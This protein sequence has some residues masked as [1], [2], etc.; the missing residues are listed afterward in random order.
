MQICTICQLPFY[1]HDR[2]FASGAHADIF[3]FTLNPISYA[4][5]DSRLFLR[6]IRSVCCTCGSHIWPVLRELPRPYIDLQDFIFWWRLIHHVGN[7][8][9]P[10]SNSTSP[11]QSIRRDIPSRIELGSG[12]I[13]GCLTDISD[14]LRVKLFLLVVYPTRSYFKNYQ[15]KH[16]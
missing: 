15:L 8:G 2:G 5:A 4:K 1:F 7:P 16:F 11:H 10:D 9:V 13:S 3:G 6:R 12:K 14:D